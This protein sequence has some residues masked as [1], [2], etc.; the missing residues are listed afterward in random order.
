[1][2]QKVQRSLIVK[3]RVPDK[4]QLI[5]IATSQAKKMFPVTGNVT[6]RSISPFDLEI[7]ENGGYTVVV[8][9]ECSVNRE[10]VAAKSPRR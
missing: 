1:M 2:M 3:G 10:V 4:R 9:F 7:G 5:D 8:E 6:V